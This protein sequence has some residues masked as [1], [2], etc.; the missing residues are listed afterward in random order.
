M[1]G[2]F[3]M[4]SKFISSLKQE[5]GGYNAA[6]LTMDLMAGLTVAAVAL[7]LALAFG[8]SSGADA[9]S[10]LITA[11]IAGLI[12]SLLSGGYY[13]ISGPTGA[14]AAIL[15]SLVAAYGMDGVFI[16]TLIAGI[17]LLLAGIL[18]L[19]KLTSFI[20]APDITGFT[21]G[22][23]VTIVIGQLKDFF[24]VTYP[25][26]METIETM[27]KLKAFAA[28]FGSVN[29]HAII[30]GVVCLAI[31]IVMPMLIHSL[32]LKLSLIRIVTL[33]SIHF[34]KLKL[35]LILI[36]KLMSTHF[37]KLR[38]NLT[39][40]VMRSL[41]HLL[42][43]FQKDFLKHSLKGMLMLPL[44][45]KEKMRQPLTQ[46]LKLMQILPYLLI[47]IE[48]LL[49]KYFLRCFEMYLKMHSLY[50]LQTLTR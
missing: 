11:I 35:S 28:G 32:K 6:A 50:L 18:H 10:G 1:K 5:F 37:L 4:L 30:V 3:V 20:P 29:L 8:V 26:G 23:A 34:L 42:R 45:E 21:S 36:V 14:M 40:T 44:I 48:T 13:Q 27:Q 47:Q 43:H 49:L 12:M 24:G 15:M 39:L 7:P 17:I 31:L 16:A 46:M 2:E 38:L 22:I 19:G 33:M 25:A 9:A 41:M